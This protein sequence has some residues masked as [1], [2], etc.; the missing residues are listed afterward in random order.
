MVDLRCKGSEHVWIW[1][2]HIPCQSC[3]TQRKPFPRASQ[4]EWLGMWQPAGQ[5]GAR[6]FLASPAASQSRSHGPTGIRILKRLGVFV[7]WLLAFFFFFKS[8]PLSALRL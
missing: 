8:Q 1:N 7:P 3:L 6:R 5:S 4:E 2:R